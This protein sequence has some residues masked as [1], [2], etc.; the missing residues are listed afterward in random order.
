MKNNL[1]KVYEEVKRED[2]IIEEEKK[3][4]KGNALI[5]WFRHNIKKSIYCVILL[6]L[7]GVSAVLL[8]QNKMSDK[9]IRKLE[10]KVEA[11]KSKLDAA[12]KKRYER[13]EIET[14]QIM[15][16]LSEAS[17]LTTY[18]YEYTNKTT[19]SST[20]MLPVLGWDI[21]GTTNSVTIQ[22]SGVINVGYDMNEIDYAISEKDAAI[23]V[24]LPKAEVFDNYIKFDDLKCICDNNILNPIRTDSVMEYF[25]EIEQEEL[26]N[27]KADE[28]FDKADGQMKEIVKGYL[29]VIPEYEVRFS[30]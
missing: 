19:E 26:A 24:T 7:V 21:L 18:I 2:V 3:A 22:Y 30:R 27:A 29:G 4:N 23:Y 28:I 12:E 25:E 8:F 13:I 17:N 1:P 9:E 5:A 11:Q 15:K 20:R 10:K 16:K 6:L 14:E